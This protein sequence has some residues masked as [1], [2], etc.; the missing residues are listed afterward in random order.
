MKNSSVIN[1]SQLGYRTNL[2]AQYHRD[3]VQE[4]AKS[5][6]R[7]VSALRELVLGRGHYS[8]LNNR[9]AL[10]DVLIAGKEYED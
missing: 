5:Y 6:Y 10:A 1:L 4:E 7:R 8:T 3:G 2:G 9:H